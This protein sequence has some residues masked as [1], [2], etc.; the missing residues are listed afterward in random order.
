MNPAVGVSLCL[1]AERNGVV[2]GELISRESRTWKVV[3]LYS[4]DLSE[5]DRSNHEFYQECNWV[6]QDLHSEVRHSR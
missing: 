2:E 4:G 1:F 5:L 6:P 3:F